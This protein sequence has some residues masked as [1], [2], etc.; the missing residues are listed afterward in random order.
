M[1]KLTCLLALTVIAVGCGSSAAKPS[2]TPTP[3][4]GRVVYQGTEWAVVVERGKAVAERLVG[5]VWQAAPRGSVKIRVLGP[6][7]GSKGNA[8]IPQVAA[9]LSAGTDLVDSALWVDGIELLGKGG[10]ITPTRGTIYGAPAASLAR[11]RHTAIAY[12][13]TAT[14]ALAV[15]WS[16]SV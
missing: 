2:G 12:A 7:P 13:R 8:R 5:D 10:G 6:E 3:G 15:S 11:G 16:F 14:N 4:P 9:E 1:A